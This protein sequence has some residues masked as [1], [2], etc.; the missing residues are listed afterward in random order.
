[1]PRLNELSK[2]T[3]WKSLLGDGDISD[4]KEIERTLIK[5]YGKVSIPEIMQQK[6]VEIPGKM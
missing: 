1:M 3:Q 5:S 4:N 6:L 2:L